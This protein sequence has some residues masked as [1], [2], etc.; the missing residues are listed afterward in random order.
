MGLFGFFDGING[1]VVVLN[2][3]LNGSIVEIKFGVGKVGM[4]GEVVI[5]SV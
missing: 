4:I 1:R 5:E 2:G 3:V